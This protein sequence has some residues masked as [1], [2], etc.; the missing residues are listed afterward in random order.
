MKTKLKTFIIMIILLV[1]LSFIYYYPKE[2]INTVLSAINIWFYNVL[3]T[4]FPFFILSDLFINYGIVDLISELFKKVMSLFNLSG[5]C[6]FVLLGSF[7]SGIPSGAKYTKQLLDNSDI[8]VDEANHLITFTHFSNP[9]F[10]IGTVGSVLLDN[11]KLGYI[12]LI[13][14][15]LGNIIIG[16]LFRKRKYI[17]KESISFKKAFL[18]MHKKRISN[19]DNFITILA[20]SIYNTIDILFLLLGI[21][22]IFLLLSS[23][24][25]KFISND[26]ILLLLKGIM[27][28]TQGVK[29]V[30]NSDLSLLLKTIFITFFIS[31]GGLSV[32]LQ[33]SSIINES[34]IK[35]KNFLKAR[36]IHSF[37][38]SILVYIF[39]I[40]FNF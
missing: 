29:Y 35:Y 10:I 22:I 9:L 28:M 39:Y 7:I 34:K 3:P 26:Y 36:I 8:T 25:S 19:K 33:I 27:E 40:L 14:H 30:S 21:I 32:H 31:F 1:I 5:N 24:I 38:S 2:T 37:I 13:S 4:L 16:L 11:V 17:E 15:I 23:F 20:N 6:S 18:A 12:I